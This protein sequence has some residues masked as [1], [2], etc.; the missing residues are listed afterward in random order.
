MDKAKTITIDPKMF[1]SK[2]YIR[3]PKCKKE[4]SFG[5]LMVNPGHFTRRCRKCWH[6][7]TYRLP[8][9]EKKVL[10]LDQFVISNMMK[11]INAKLGKTEKVDKT[12]LRMFK[13]LDELVKLQLIICP[14]SEFHRQESLLSFYAALKRMY[15]HLSHVTTFFDRHTI[16]RFQVDDGFK[17]LVENKDFDWKSLGVD[18]VLHGDRNEWQS[19]FLITIDSKIDP[20]EI[21]DFQNQ[22]LKIHENV[23][24]LFETWKNARGKS[25][26]DYYKEIV[27]A[28]G[29][30]IA[31]SYVESI[32][33]YFQASLGIKT[34][35]PEEMIPV[36]MG[37]ESIIVSSLQRHLP[38]EKDE[39]KLKRVISYLQSE[40]TQNLPFNEIYSTLWAA[41][42]YQ[43]GAGGRIN[44]PNIGMVN[45]IEMV[46]SL[47]PYCDAMFVDRDM[48]SLL[49]FGAVKRIVDKYNTKVFSL[50]NKEEFFNYL[51]EIKEKASEKH[52]KCIREVY[53][54][55]W[56]TPYLEMFE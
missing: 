49:N 56:P 1:I 6:D 41:I 46:S 45:D 21:E 42:A 7:G 15:E 25:F 13:E 27:P 5:V 2:P 39:E 53:G 38:N 36:M 50:A 3:C 29:N 24:S 40:R 22:R 17:S 14:D 10:Y 54:E 12:Y 48:D 51:S 28:Y 52:M 11:A 55:D 47:L 9:L 33:Q 16:E 34:F 19:R 26:N 20:K 31:K 32:M 43:A 8:E 35:T 44:P 18:N 30:R 23:K 37:E 4:D